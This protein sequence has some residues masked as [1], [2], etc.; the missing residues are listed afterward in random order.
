[1]IVIFFYAPNILQTL[2]IILNWLINFY[3][4]KA[5]VFILVL[6]LTRNV[7]YWTDKVPD[8]FLATSITITQY[9]LKGKL[10]DIEEEMV[11]ETEV[12]K[13]KKVKQS[14]NKK[15]EKIDEMKKSIDE[16]KRLMDEKDKKIDEIK[17]SI[18]EIKKY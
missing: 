11:D 6:S 10:K 4:V 1:M 2:L 17:R 8:K 18:N 3:F 12:K 13:G 7:S 14:M 15:D 16:M 9:L 5:C